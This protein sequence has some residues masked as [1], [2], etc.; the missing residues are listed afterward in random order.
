MPLSNRPVAIDIGS[1]SVK[2]AQVQQGRGGVRSIRCAQERLPE[3]FRWDAPD[4]VSVLAAAVRS[5]M[6]KAGI[7]ARAAVMSLPR[8]HVTARIASFPPADKAQLR[9]VVEYDLADHLPFP[10]E[11]VVMDLQSLGTSREEPGLVDVLVVAAQ[12]ELIQRYLDVAKAAGLKLA[13]LTIDSLALHD[14]TT[15]LGSGPPGLT[16]A[17]S[18]GHRSA[19]INISQGGRLWLTRSAPLGGQQLTAAIQE[20]LGITAEEAEE[21]K[22]SEGIASGP[23]GV[24][25]PRVQTWLDNLCGELTRSA[26]SFG[27]AA[28]SRIL[29]FG[30]GAHVPGLAE[31]IAREMGVSPQTPTLADLFSRARLLTDP[32]EVDACLPVIGQALRG[33]GQSEWTISLLP[34]ELMQARRVRRLRALGAAGGAAVAAALIVCYLFSA[35][36]I[37]RLE[38]ERA[39]L[40]ALSEQTAEL[41][42]IATDLM[43]TRDRLREQAAVM[44]E[45]LQQRHAALEIIRTLSEQGSPKVRI[46]SLSMG[47]DQPLVIRGTAPD[48]ATVA[49]LQVVLA[50]SPLLEDVKVEN[51]ARALDR[52][53][54]WAGPRSSRRVE[55]TA[56]GYVSFVIKAK[57]VNK[58]KPRTGTTTLAR[59]GGGR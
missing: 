46:L 9:R 43:N 24:P 15:R 39:E 35:R 45:A 48:P 41:Q 22:I 21:K 33:V 58:S 27:Q 53:G 12:R 51:A 16:V 56:K 14:L 17:V 10:V 19:T 31:A 37:T 32:A 25:G 18:I 29:L 11:Q 40:S 54:R 50:A 26:L 4:G 23:D 34:P 44:I 38:S 47:R 20:D 30:A 13:A 59:A 6:A 28:V 3:N 42:A 55:P 57:L 36:A 8:R 1:Q 5:A 49:D 2:V 52:P 7:R